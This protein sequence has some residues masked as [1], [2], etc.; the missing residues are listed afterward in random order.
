MSG[1]VGTFR[2]KVSLPSVER[3]DVSFIMEIPLPWSV[4]LPFLPLIPF[5]IRKNWN[6]CVIS[7]SIV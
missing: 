2:T 7:C 4:G 6:K 5:R 1:M 3:E